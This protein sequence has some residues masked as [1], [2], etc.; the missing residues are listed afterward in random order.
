[1]NDMNGTDAINIILYMREKGIAERY[2]QSEYNI[3]SRILISS[4]EE[5]EAIQVKLREPNSVEITGKPI[6]KREMEKLLRKY[7]GILVNKYK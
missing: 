4:N 2:Y 7:G 1:M 3:L 6:N 5:V